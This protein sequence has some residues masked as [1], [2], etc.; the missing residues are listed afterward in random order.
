MKTVRRRAQPCLQV[1]ELLK[2]RLGDEEALFVDLAKKYG[3]AEDP[4]LADL[5]SLTDLRLGANEL[6]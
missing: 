4:M 1:D 2:K 5:V 6:V 3:A